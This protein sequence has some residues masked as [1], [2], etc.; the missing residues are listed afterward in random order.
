MR[1]ILL[2]VP[3]AGKGTQA[4]L[5]SKKFNVPQISTGDIFRHNLRNETPLG[6]M[7]KEY[8]DKGLLVP[9]E[10]T[11]S[12]VQDRLAKD[13]CKN[14]FILDGFPRTLPQSKSLDHVLHE[15]RISLDCA[16]NFDVADE[17]IVK[18]LTGRRV[19][20][21][22]GKTFHIEYEPPKEQDL[23]DTCHVSLVQRV[24][25]KEETVTKRLLAYH[26]Q[27]EPLIEYYQRK[28]I[29]VTVDATK[30]INMISSEIASYIENIVHSNKV[31]TAI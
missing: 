23:C 25:D 13:D 8:M 18:R 11:V 17:V 12:L 9:D 16:I 10:I 22:C 1:I 30:Q 6:K 29:L 31:R 27:T 4:V 14:G 21:I 26:E 7:A 28:N 19:C 15:M 5:L 24:D 3:G 2:G 20:P